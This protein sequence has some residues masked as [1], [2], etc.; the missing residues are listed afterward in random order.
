MTK[1]IWHEFPS[2][3][4]EKMFRHYIR[5]NITYKIRQKL[6]NISENVDEKMRKYLC[7]CKAYAHI[8]SNQILMIPECA[9]CVTNMYSS[10]YPDTY[11]NVSWCT[12]YI[13]RWLMIWPSFA[14]N[15]SICKGLMHFGFLAKKRCHYHLLPFF[16]RLAE[17]QIGE[18]LHIVY[19]ISS[20]SD[21]LLEYFL[22]GCWKTQTKSLVW[23]NIR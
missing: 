22:Y 7:N 9:T 17:Y 21:H 12:P 11:R 18:V 13:T 19:F 3:N 16:T 2:K 14:V 4:R 20:G 5:K 1:S 6:P 15:V 10:M 23:S 8:R